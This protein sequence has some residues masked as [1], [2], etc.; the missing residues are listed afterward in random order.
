MGYIVNIEG[1]SKFNNG[2]NH[3]QLIDFCDTIAITAIWD[4]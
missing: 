4:V 1:M 3:W 2:T